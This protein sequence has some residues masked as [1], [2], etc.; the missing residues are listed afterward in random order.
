MSAPTKSEGAPNPPQLKKLTYSAYRIGVN[1]SR[2]N[3]TRAGTVKVKAV[4]QSRALRASGR[5][6]GPP[7]PGFSARTGRSW[8]VPVEVI[9]IHW[10]LATWVME[11]ATCSGDLAPAMRPATES[12]TSWPTAGG[13]AW[14]G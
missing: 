4:S 8:C 12:L 5:R 3:R 1:T 13:Y 14:S 9:V 10:L 6:L 2:P 7:V 11:R